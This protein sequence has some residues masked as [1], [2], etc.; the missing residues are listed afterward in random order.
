MPQDDVPL[1]IPNLKAPQYFFVLSDSKLPHLHDDAR[2][3][4]AKLIQ[5]DGK[6]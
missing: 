4:L 1:P 2:K 6:P 3:G 5:D